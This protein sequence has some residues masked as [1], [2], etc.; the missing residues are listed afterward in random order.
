MSDGYTMIRLEKENGIAWIVLNRPNKLNAINREMLQELQAALREIEADKAIRSLI[1]IGEGDRAFSV[2]ADIGWLSKLDSE[3][4]REL[5]EMGQGILR[6]VAEMPIPVIAAVNGYALGGGFEL[7][8]A[9]DF[10]IASETAQ[11]GNPEA[12]LGIIPGWGGI[13]RLV[14]TVGLPMAKG[15]LM[16]G[17]RIRA[18]EAL[19]IG[20]VHKTVPPEQLREEA[21]AL[22]RKLAEAAPIALRSLKQALRL[23]PQL[24]TAVRAE[25]EIALFSNLFSTEDASEGLKA[26]LEKRKPKFKGNSRR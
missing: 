17:D 5:S 10:R 23:G 22:A 7:A 18:P 24:P 8:L 11:F 6:E 3:G 14:H 15:L 26:F 16:L 13:Q 1:L 12:K 21:R 9:C 19:E 20:L 4:A 2:G 25:Q